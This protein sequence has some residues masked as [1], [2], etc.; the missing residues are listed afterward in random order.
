MA[1]NEKLSLSLSEK[2]LTLML[3]ENI[4]FEK[5]K[6]K[7]DYLVRIGADV[8]ANVYGKSMALWAKEQGDEEVIKYIK[9]NGGVESQISKEKSYELGIQFWNGSWAVK[10][11]DEI[12]ELVL[13]G[14]DLSVKNHNNEQVWKNLSLEEMNEILKDLPKGY[15]IEGDVDLWNKNLKEL[16]NF[17]GIKIGGSFYCSGNELT[18]LSGAPEK[19]GGVFNCTSNQLTTLQDAPSEVGGDFKCSYNQLTDLKGAPREIKGDFWCNYNQLTTLKG[20]PEKVGES[21]ECRFNQLTTLQSAPETVGG[22][23]DCSYNNQLKD[24]RGAPSVVGGAFWC[25]HNNKLATLEGGPSEVGGFFD[26]SCNQ[27]TDLR[28]APRK[29]GVDFNCKGNRLT[30]LDG[31]PQKIGGEFMI[32]EEV[33]AR[34]KKKSIKNILGKLFGGSDG[35]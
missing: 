25:H 12:K 18:D 1:E 22:S 31:K 10:S 26:C 27:L 4:A 17:E 35:M 15:V 2:L 3:N 19:V 23:F 28:G 24:L 6:G 14:A 21:F 13:R 9:E 5:K 20:A 32:E 30:T 8:N 16:P 33:L 7:M 34:I 11:V 29:V